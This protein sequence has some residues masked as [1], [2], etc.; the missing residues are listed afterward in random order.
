[1]ME[2]KH[3]YDDRPMV[4]AVLGGAI[5][6]ALDGPALVVRDEGSLV[7]TDARWGR[8]FADSDHPAG[9]STVS[10][11]LERFA[12]GRTM[13]E[14]LR[15]EAAPADRVVLRLDPERSDAGGRF[16]ARLIRGATIKADRDAAIV[17][18]TELRGDAEDGSDAPVPLEQIQRLLVRQSLIEERERRRLG[19]AVHDHVTQLLVQVRWSLADARD[20]RSV[21]RP[22]EMGADIDRVIKML[23]ELTSNYS[24]PVLEDLGLVPAIQWLVEHL[25]TTYGATAECDDD[26]LEPRLSPEVRTICFRALRELAINAAKHAPGARIILSSEVDRDRYHLSVCDDGPGFEPEKLRVGDDASTGYGLLSV[27]QQILAV[28]GTF[29]IR[30]VSGKGTRATITLP[31]GPEGGRESA[32]HGS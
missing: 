23:Q 10:A 20:G 7:S 32:T 5:L 4:D 19:R 27:Q 15:R 12:D 18:L 29:A 17:M 11:W 2:P 3:E 14:A 31:E 16:V 22:A 9:T 25:Q 26:G 24:P 1:M 6:D 28:G 13:L 21:L 8:L 30:S